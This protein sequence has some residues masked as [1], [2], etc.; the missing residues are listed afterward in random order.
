MFLYEF[1]VEKQCC[2]CA[3]PQIEPVSI[4]IPGPPAAQRHPQPPADE[5]LA[6]LLTS[7]IGLGHQSCRTLLPFW[8][9]SSAGWLLYPKGQHGELLPCPRS[10]VTLK[11]QELTYIPHRQQEAFL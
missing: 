6:P 2:H 7:V 5:L 10:E 9:E 8:G 1:L 11:G 4:W 3:I